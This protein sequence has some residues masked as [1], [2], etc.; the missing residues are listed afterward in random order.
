MNNVMISKDMRRN[1]FIVISPFIQFTTIEDENLP[2]RMWKIRPLTNKLV[3]NFVQYFKPEQ[4]LTFDESM[5][6]YIAYGYKVWS[7]KTPMG[8]QV[9]IEVYQVNNR[10][11]HPDFGRTYGKCVAPLLQMAGNF[12]VMF[13]ISLF[14]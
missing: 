3:E 1:R 13:L 4:H 14:I 9:S 5:I 7:S 6:A 8:Y 12:P 10:Y 11:I 2:D